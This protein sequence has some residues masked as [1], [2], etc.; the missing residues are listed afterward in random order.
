MTHRILVIDDDELVLISME[1]LLKASGFDVVMAHNGQEGLTLAE[2]STFDIV[3]TDM[4]MPGISGLDV[5]R[6]LRKMEKY[7]STPIVMLTAKS[8]SKDRE[9]GKEAGVD[10]FLGKP[11]DPFKLLEIIKEISGKLSS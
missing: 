4:I 7:Q 5:V 1:E 2:Q 3:V 9:N 11:M 6:S 8:E 10:E